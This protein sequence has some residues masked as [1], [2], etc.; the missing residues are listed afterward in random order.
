M[1][2]IYLN[3][4]NSEIKEVDIDE[5]LSFI[6]ESETLLN[7][8]KNEFLNKSIQDLYVS[9]KK[10]VIYT[11]YISEIESDK[12]NIT[13]KQ[14]MVKDAL[15]DK[16]TI[17]VTILKNGHQFTFKTD[18]KGFLKLDNRYSIYDI[19]AKDRHKYKELFKRN[20]YLFDEIT[21]IKYGKQKIYS[22]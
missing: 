11:K 19:Q 10:Y 9:F 12:S 21:S 8:Y 13:H 16:K 6:Q 22:N 1:D 7:H 14:K 15:K 20:D 2:F 3:F 4:R 17:N 18:T 5:V